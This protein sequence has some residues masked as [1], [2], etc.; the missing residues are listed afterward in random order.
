MK[1]ILLILLLVF[2][3]NLSAQY[4]NPYRMTFD[5][6]NYFITNK[7]NGTVSKLDSSFAHSTVITGLYSPNDIFFGSIAGNSAIMVLDSNIIKLFSPTT[8]TSLL[9]IPITGAVEA[10]DGVYNPN[11]SN[12][13]F[14]SDRAGNKIIKGVVGSAP[15]YPITFSTLVSNITK[16]AGMIFN[17]QGKLIVVSDTIGSKVYEIN[18][19]TGGK[20][21]LLSTTL[22]NFNDIA[23]DNEGNYYITCW[24]NNNL[25]R[26]DN[27]L[28]S[29][30]VV[31][32]FNNP[33]G[34]YS[35]LAYDYLGLACY[36]C[37]KVE[38]KYYHLFSPLDDVTTCVS[39]SF[40]ADFTPT[41]FGIGTYN[42]DNKFEVEMSDSNGSF[43]SPKTIGSTTDSIRPSYIKAAIPVN[44]YASSGYKYRLKSTSPEHFSYFEK[45][46]TILPQ[47]NAN[48]NDGD[49]AYACIGINR[50][51]SVPHDSN[52]EYSWFPPV[53]MLTTGP[54]S[55]LFTYTSKD[56]VYPYAFQVKDTS[57]G[58]VSL[59]FFS[60]RVKASAEITGLQDTLTLCSGD[61]VDIGVDALPY[62]YTWQGS[63]FLD[64]YS[65]SNPQFFGTTSTEL[66]VTFSDS[67][68][69]CYGTDSVYVT[70][71]NLGIRNQLNNEFTT[72]VGDTISVG[73][74]S[75]DYQYSWYGS[76][77]LSSFSSSNPLF[78]GNQ[79]TQLEVLY[80]DSLNICSDVD[81]IRIHVI[82]LPSFNQWL[83]SF[84]VCKNDTLEIGITGNS[85]YNY[86]WDSSSLLSDN[87]ISNPLFYANIDSFHTLKLTVMDTSGLCSAS[88][89]T[90][91]Y[92]IPEASKPTLIEGLG[93]IYLVNDYGGTY[94]WKYFD[95]NTNRDTFVIT[96]TN[97]LELVSFNFTNAISVEITDSNGCVVESYI[98]NLIREGVD[99]YS[100]NL[101][102]VPNPSNGIFYIRTELPMQNVT[103]LDLTGKL[104]N[105][106]KLSNS[107][108]YD[109]KFDTLSSGTY[110]I[111]VTT[112]LGIV[113]KRVIIN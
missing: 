42:G 89:T 51:F 57:T 36:N 79:T 32:T 35:N 26:Y 87:A 14:I 28:S 110:I 3:F 39:D 111:E 99:E 60:I 5:G 38:F 77:N 91:A 43:N 108:N 19:S 62:M 92:V 7:G 47:P 40:F 107:F 64:N 74:D 34:L 84:E 98:Y 27:T 109:A 18:I 90:V 103:I 46:L 29:P 55:F 112:D 81:T 50:A 15:F 10:H 41:D 23:Q 86:T 65:S 8:Y 102:I 1:T 93:W 104:I 49:T 83:D 16:P 97:A 95:Y 56:S 11:N 21:T 80:S 82:Q 67:S 2:S 94:R 37:Q 70:V 6:T 45:E 13:F 106:T 78:Y 75:F 101:K 48:I 100:I 17:D 25:Y 76:P 52:Y 9:N 33:S 22:D 63:S 44:I 30:Y 72:C 12:E 20:T 113:R 88:Q 58:C 24:G 31:A 69:T 105:A 4:N 73:I 59:D 61:S 85:N 68:Q 71:G 54:G 53:G 66:F 96:D